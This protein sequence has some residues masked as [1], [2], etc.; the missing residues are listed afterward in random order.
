MNDDQFAKLFSYVE[1][2][3][4]AVDQKLDEKSDKSDVELI[5]RTIDGYASK[6]DDYAVEM[7]AM[8]SKINRLERMIDYLADQA[9]VSRKVLE[10]L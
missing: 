1:K 5:I 8:Q 7:A 2:R 10:S 3:F 9:G 6:L 4:D